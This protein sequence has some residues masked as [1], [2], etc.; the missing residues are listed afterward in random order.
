M[1]STNYRPEHNA[2]SERVLGPRSTAAT[3]PMMASARRANVG[4][5]IELDAQRRRSEYARNGSVAPEPSCE[6]SRAVE[7]LEAALYLV[8]RM[9]DDVDDLARLA[10]ERLDL[11]RRLVDWLRRATGSSL[12][13]NR[14]TGRD[15]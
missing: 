14:E 7:R 11:S 5:A 4:A 9:V 6:C 3:D 1:P 15:A 2:P 13:S 8:Y 10:L 12:A